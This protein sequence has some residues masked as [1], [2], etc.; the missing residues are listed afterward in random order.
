MEMP[1]RLGTRSMDG[2]PEWVRS[3]GAKSDPKLPGQQPPPTGISSGQHSNM[4]GLAGKPA[5]CQ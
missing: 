4:L 5:L 2:G 1:P 3:R